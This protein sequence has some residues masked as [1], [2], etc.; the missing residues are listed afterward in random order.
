MLQMAYIL[1][2][3]PISLITSSN[4][5]R[6]YDTFSCS[7]E[8]P[9]ARLK[10]KQNAWDCGHFIFGNALNHFLWYRV[11]ILC[12][13]TGNQNKNSIDF[14]CWVTPLERKSSKS[15]CPWLPLGVDTNFQD[16]TQKGL[17]QFLKSR[18]CFTCFYFSNP[19]IEV[20]FHVTFF[21][22]LFN[23]IY[24]QNIYQPQY[25]ECF[26]PPE[27]QINNKL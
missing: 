10:R 7:H 13:P 8:A 24:V 2:Y 20:I 15:K 22:I 3:K 16:F 11:G 14:L 26:K 27:F 23:A 9:L 25:W 4:R 21:I 18:T 17:H 5:W 1:S 6:W 19:N 12:V